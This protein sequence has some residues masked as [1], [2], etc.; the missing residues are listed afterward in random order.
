MKKVH[1]Q[2]PALIRRFF[3][4]WTS[5]ENVFVRS[6]PS[7]YSQGS[8]SHKPGEGSLTLEASVTNV[9]NSFHLI[10]F[11]GALSD[12][13]LGL[14]RSYSIGVWFRSHR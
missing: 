9:L 7:I 14:P 11:A 10:N 2:R 6:T 8:I 4:L 3:D 1:S 12:T 13:A 5:N